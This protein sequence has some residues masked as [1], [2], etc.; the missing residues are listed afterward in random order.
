MAHSS[1]KQ[2]KPAGPKSKTIGLLAQFDDPESLVAACERARDAGYQK[3]DAYSPFP[4][5]GIDPAMG[6]SRTRLPFFVLAIGLT[7]CLVALAMQYYMNAVDWTKIFPGYAFFIS[8]KPLEISPANI[9]VTFEVIILSSAFAT[10]FGMWLFNRLP[11]FANPLHRINRFRRAT[12]DRFFLMVETADAKFD[13][14]RTRQ[15][16]EEWGAT[17]IENVDLDLTDQEIPKFFKMAG[18]VGMFLLLVPPVMTFRAYGSTNRAPRLHVVPDMDWQDKYK[19]QQTSPNIGTDKEPVFLYADDRAMRAPVA[20]T[21]AR[22]D[23]QEDDRYFRGYEPGT[24]PPPVKPVA[25]E[26][27]PANFVSTG[28]PNALDPAPAVQDPATAGQYPGEPKWIDAVPAPF[29]VSEAAI[30]RGKQRFEIYCSVCHGYDGNGNGLV[31]RRAL[32]LAATGQA[33]W[34]T[35]KS[36]HDPTVKVQPIGRIFDTISNG[37][38]SMG[39]YRSQIPVEDRWAIALYVKALQETGIQP[40]AGAAVPPAAPQ[41]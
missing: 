29:T 2:P 15:Q 8:G 32:A 3:F 4:V 17:A 36:I 18:I 5:H 26:S 23:L 27:S 24:L 13:A 10:F 22:G 30:A 37:R 9:P 14:N 38:N 21:V 25:A 39:P 28:G 19:A 33:Q 6:I 31:N 41:Q 34:T 1:S 40:P 7:G 20:G 16:F 35:A 12:N 11:Q